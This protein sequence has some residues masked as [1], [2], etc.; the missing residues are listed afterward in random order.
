MPALFE[1]AVV[2]GRTETI[3]LTLTQGDG[4][5]GA[6]VASGDVVRVK[7][8]RRDD[9]T[10]DLELASGQTTANGSTVTH[11]TAVPTP[12]NTAAQ[13]RVKLAQADTDGLQPGQ[14]TLEAFIVDD[15]E[16]SPVDAALGGAIGTVHILGS[17]G[18][19][20]GLP[21]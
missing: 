8:Y 11:L 20:I 9:Q 16:T 3:D 10:P 14:Y 4:S 17:G 6:S 19:D 1:V 13:V 15:S 5:T 2:R 12:A 18:G 21:S 7:L